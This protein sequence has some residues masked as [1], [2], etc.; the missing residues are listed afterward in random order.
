MKG[1]DVETRTLTGAGSPA[2]DSDAMRIAVRCNHCGHWL[3]DPISV[4]L[5]VGPR[6]RG[7]ADG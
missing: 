2:F 1:H 3:T 5:G 7:A 6:C 4:A